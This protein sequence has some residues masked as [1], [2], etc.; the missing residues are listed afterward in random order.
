[1]ASYDSVTIDYQNLFSDVTSLCDEACE[2]IPCTIV[3][4]LN[5]LSNQIGLWLMSRRFSHLSTPT[6]KD[7]WKHSSSSLTKIDWK[8]DESVGGILFSTYN[9]QNWEVTNFWLPAENK[10]RYTMAPKDAKGRR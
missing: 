6:S 4:K 5:R 3:R 10:N 8:W 2:Y 7:D 1:M 9:Y